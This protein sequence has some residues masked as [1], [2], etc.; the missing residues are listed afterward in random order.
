MMR[1][2]RFGQWALIAAATGFAYVALVGCTQCR[3]QPSSPLEQTASKLPIPATIVTFSGM[4]DASG[5]V[6]IDAN[7]LLV[8]S[9]ED[10]VLRIYDAMRGGAPTEELDLSVALNVAPPPRPPKK[11]PRASVPK[12]RPPRE[13]D[14]EAATRLGDEACFLAS[15]SKA[16]GPRSGR[17]RFV[18]FCTTLPID[19]RPL[20]L[21]GSPYRLLFED[22]SASP[23]LAGVDWDGAA[24]QRPPEEAALNVEAM[25][26]DPGGGLWIGLRSPLRDDEAILVL[27]GNPQDLP[28]GGRGRVDRVEFVDLDGLG[29]RGLTY[30]R[31]QYL[32]AA[33]P[34]S[35]GKATRVYRWTPG[36]S[37]TA[38][39]IELPTDFNVEGFFNSVETSRLMLLSD[40]GDVLVDGVACKKLDDS[41]KRGFRGMW[42]DV[43]AR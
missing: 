29:T 31:G 6:P 2:D 34:P 28:H 20:K 3:H 43:R 17:A 1:Q 23:L 35:K 42:L 15:H 38:L 40:D 36:D 16:G 14:I 33:G 24:Q 30:G 32:I 39:P 7:R 9:D 12:V 25:T 5:A 37:A 27:I 18:L 4:C 26:A 41:S 10:N 13:A 19:D 21:V 8:A 22:L 11:R